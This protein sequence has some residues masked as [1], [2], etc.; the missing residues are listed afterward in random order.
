MKPTEMDALLLPYLQA[1]DEAE[2]QRW[3]TALFTEQA[4]PLIHKLV[5]RKLGFPAGGRH[6]EWADV[7]SE[8]RVQLLTRLRTLRANPS[9]DPIADFR[10][11]VAGMSYHNCAAYLREQ[12]PQRWRV[13]A[14][15]R[16]LLTTQPQ[17][18]L[19]QNG[20]GEWLGGFIGWGPELQTR[21]LCPPEQLYDLLGS[22][23][24][25]PLLGI[26]D[27][28]FRRVS[29]AEQMA[30]LLTWADA[31]IALDELVTVFAHWWGMQDQRPHHNVIPTQDKPDVQHDL[32]TQIEQRDYL[33]KLWQEIRELPLRQRQSLLLHLQCGRAQSALVLLPALQIASLRQIAAVMEM[34]AE[35]LARLWN[36]LPLDDAHIAAQLK[37]TRRQVI[38]LRLAARE[39]LQRRTRR[40]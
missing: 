4:E 6:E 26:P 37:V 12:Y 20:H 36:Q 5:K 25:A 16:Y 14:R 15:V 2:A 29:A 11:Y 40:W 34:S 23:L 10:A 39:R 7:Y 32:E 3:L 9:E 17:F 27:A 8:T 19:W 30:A 24:P 18:G 38:N 21:R 13:T 31:F 28:T 33:Q 1:S 35:E 22:A